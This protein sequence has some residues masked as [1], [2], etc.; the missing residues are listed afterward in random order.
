MSR[1]LSCL[2]LG[3]G[4][5]CAMTPRASQVGVDDHIEARNTAEELRRR[6]EALEAENAGTADA[7]A[8]ACPLARNV[9]DLSERL[10]TLAARHSDD[11]ELE[12]LCRDGRDRCGR[13]RDKTRPCGCLKPE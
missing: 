2:A 4:A 13:A 9:C 3:V 12:R 7:C 8:Q 10:C 5:A 11:G 1:W 6:A